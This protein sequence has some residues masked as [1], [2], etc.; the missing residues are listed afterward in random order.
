M[1]RI[2]VIMLI[3]LGLSV[4]VSLIEIQR[5]SGASNSTPDYS[6]A[7]TGNPCTS[8]ECA[9]KQPLRLELPAGSQVDG[10]HCLTTANYPD[11]TSLHEVSCTTDNAWSIFDSPR[12]DTY[13]NS[14]IVSTTYYN[15][16]HNRTRTVRLTADWH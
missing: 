5:V 16:S 4:I 11:D 15:R 2:P 10:V 12:I 8:N 9:Q 6:V 3:A 13:Q 1:R 14:V 7:G